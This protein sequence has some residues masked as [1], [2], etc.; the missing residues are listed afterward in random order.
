[1]R[2]RC[3]AGHLASGRGGAVLPL[4]GAL[5]VLP[6]LSFLRADCRRAATLAP[7]ADYG[8]LL[9]KDQPVAEGRLTKAALVEE[10]ADVADLTKKHAEV[11]VETVLGG[12]VDALQ[13][14]EKV[15]L[16]G[17]G[18]F[19]FRRRL[20]RKGRNPKTGDRVDVPSKRVLYFKPGKE[21]KELI[22]REQTQA[23]PPPLS[24]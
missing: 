13:R 14:G 23:I 18:S 15:E 8:A 6:L 11:I 21:L 9:T 22:N 12:I 24:D 20:P 16:R 1:M 5:T 7:G 3:W 19:R 4:A 2:S 10:V 17:F